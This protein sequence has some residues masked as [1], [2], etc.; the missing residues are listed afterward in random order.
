MGMDPNITGGSRQSQID[1]TFGTGQ[2]GAA[3]EVKVKTPAGFEGTQDTQRTADE[4]EPAFFSNANDPKLPSPK[5]EVLKT[6]ADAFTSQPPDPEIAA[7]IE[8]LFFE[9]TDQQFE[10]KK[11]DKEERNTLVF[12]FKTGK[13][14]EIKDPELKKL[15]QEIQQNVHGQIE[16]KYPEIKE[17]FPRNSETSLQDLSNIKEHELENVM[18]DKGLLDSNGIP[19][20]EGLEV[21]HAIL[22]GNVA[23]G[24]KAAEVLTTLNEVMEQNFGKV[25]IEVNHTDYLVKLGTEFES[26]VLQKAPKGE[27]KRFEYLFHHPDPSDPLQPKVDKARSEVM[28]QMQEMYGFPKDFK[29]AE[30]SVPLDAKLNGTYY[31]T[32]TDLIDAQSAV[33]TD[34]DVKAI[35][36]FI[37]AKIE[38]KPFDKADFDTS[39]SMEQ[40][41]SIGEGAHADALAKVQ[42]HFDVPKTW[43]PDPTKSITDFVG[44]P[45]L[46]SVNSLKQ[47]TAVIQNQIDNNPNIS[48]GDRITLNNYLKVISDALMELN[49]L[50]YLIQAKEAEAARGATDTKLGMIK[51]KEAKANAM[52]SKRAELREERQAQFEEQKKAQEEQEKEDKKEGVFSK[53]P[54][55]G[56]IVGAV[57]VATGVGAPLGATIL[58]YT[59]PALVLSTPIPGTAGPDGKDRS[60]SE[61]FMQ[62]VVE[63]I[64]DAAGENAYQRAKVKA[65]RQ[66]LS[67]EQAELI[68]Q[69]A[70]LT[71]KHAV[72]ATLS[73]VVVTVVVGVSIATGNPA[74]GAT[75][76]G[77]LL[78]ETGIMEQ[79]IKDLA[80]TSESGREWVKDNELSIMIISMAATVVLSAGVA[81]AAK[82]G[83]KQAPRALGKAIASGTKRGARAVGRGAKAVG[84]G[85]AKGG[86]AVGRGAKAVGQGIAK[87]GRAA[88]GG[89][90]NAAIRGRSALSNASTNIAGLADDA[91]NIVRNVAQQMVDEIRAMIQMLQ[92]L[93]LQLASKAAPQIQGVADDAARIASS[94]KTIGQSVSETGR[95]AASYA[96]ELPGRA[97]RGTKNAVKN[98]DPKLMAMNLGITAFEAAPMIP[99]MIHNFKMAEIY[100][101]L[102]EH[103]DRIAEF[104]E[105]IGVF[106]ADLDFIETLIEMFTKFIEK[107][108]EKH[109]D[110]NEVIKGIQKALPKNYQAA[111]A[112][113][114]GW[115]AIAG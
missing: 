25:N 26:A 11:I 46:V 72:Q 77:T 53:I 68:A 2:T 56:T 37:K 8:A 63:K 104:T 55:I 113:T 115:D 62:E 10:Q 79:L 112:T 51:D 98:T 86:K 52:L 109:E 40:I 101:A 18:R 85:V 30:T 64:G 82:T 15:F 102:A 12:A 105:A 6:V 92:K 39:L 83:L 107:I 29:P 97:W 65:I 60:L 36:A 45:G 48:S 100:E 58:A 24:T 93:L 74:I 73:V 80:M 27:E 34:G 42:A 35:V 75:I 16:D 32:L 23:P 110:M 17:P 38:G 91:G 71:A 59:V 49:E 114:E 96:K 106:Q 67:P 54:I 22:S 61:L 108:N 13:E 43:S 41:K 14:G 7:E 69:E 5:N 94:G 3:E 50:M 20:K 103:S 21:R 87:G 1:S 4:R 89:I 90:R 28:T 76:A 95:R 78:A 84:E 33:K 31:N 70:R 99:Q 88:A 9:E 81:G 66:G 47:Y 57:L 111:K 19:T 44:G